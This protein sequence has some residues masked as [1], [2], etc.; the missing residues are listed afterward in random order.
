MMR[1]LKQLWRERRAARAQRRQRRHRD[2]SAGFTMLEIMIA[3]AIVAAV[4]AG[5]GVYAFNQYKKAQ[6]RIAKQRVQEIQQGVN[7]FMI[8]NNN[9][10]RTLEELVAQKYVAKGV[11][12]DPWGKDFTMKCPGTAD[13]E[14]ADIVSAGPDKQDGTPDDIKS[15]DL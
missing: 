5:V 2:G 11:A 9:C 8:D 6:I 14:S 15:S 12:K 7:T 13:P 1:Y 10:P 3:L 4:G